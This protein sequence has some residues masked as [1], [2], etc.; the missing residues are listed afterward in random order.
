MDPK[1][2]FKFSS[3]LYVVAASHGDDVGACLINTGM[4]LTA[5][6]AAS[7]GCY[8]QRKPYGICCS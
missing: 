8:Q 4:Q 3:G 6:P 1:A 2:L 5:E 7:A